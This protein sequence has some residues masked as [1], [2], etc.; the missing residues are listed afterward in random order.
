MR[1]F[2]ELCFRIENG[3]IMSISY[4]TLLA[5]H[6]SEIRSQQKGTVDVESDTQKEGPVWNL[7]RG[8]ESF[9]AIC[10]EALK[11]FQAVLPMKLA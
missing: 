6:V 5:F 4:G 11:N 10:S 9:P 3:A 8:G 2:G 7:V 1:N